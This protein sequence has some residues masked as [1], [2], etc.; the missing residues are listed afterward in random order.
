MI[1]ACIY[2]EYVSPHPG[3]SQTRQQETIVLTDPKLVQKCGKNQRPLLQKERQ[4][5]LK[6]KTKMQSNSL[7]ASVEVND[8]EFDICWECKKV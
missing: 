2:F 8:G 6:E 1:P 4:K 5:V 3:T 7:L